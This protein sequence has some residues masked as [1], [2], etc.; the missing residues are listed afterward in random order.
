MVLVLRYN[1][2]GFSIYDLL[3]KYID[4]VSWSLRYESRGRVC[5]AA[6]TQPQLELAHS[7]C[8]KR[9]SFFYVLCR[10]RV[11]TTSGAATRST[12]VHSGQALYLYTYW[13]RKMNWDF[14]LLFKG[15]Q[16]HSCSLKL[17]RYTRITEY[18]PQ[19]QCSSRLGV[20][21]IYFCSSFS[22]QRFLDSQ[23][24]YES[25]KAAFQ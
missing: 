8:H 15:S 12:L 4:D 24:L 14:M 22:R 11:P 18:L 2:C 1:D 5:S 17:Y 3:V 16:Q 10:D 23:V 21:T 20:S 6:A 13:L 19:Q 7:Y 25:N 9:Y